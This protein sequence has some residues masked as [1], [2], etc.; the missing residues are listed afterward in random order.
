M[1]EGGTVAAQYSRI[2]N[3]AAEKRA[4]GTPNKQLE[5]FGATK[6]GGAYIVRTHTSYNLA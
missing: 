5:S 2:D 4:A 6:R 3:D 1:Y